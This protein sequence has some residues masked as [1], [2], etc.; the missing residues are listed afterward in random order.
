MKSPYILAAFAL[1]LFVFSCSASKTTPDYS[2]VGVWDI[3]V[4]NEVEGD[5]PIQLVLTKAGDEYEGII[6][7]QGDEDRLQD[8][9]ITGNTIQCAF[10]VMSFRGSLN[11][12]FAGNRITGTFFM[13][14][15]GMKMKG[16]RVRE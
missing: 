9:V 15:L 16:K 13:Q 1:S 6:K 10:S 12:T 14:S 4:L 8:L 7:A 3:T 11:G 5:I 2:P